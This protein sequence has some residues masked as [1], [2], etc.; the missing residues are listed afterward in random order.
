MKASLETNKQKMKMKMKMNNTIFWIL[1]DTEGQSLAVSCQ[2][3]LLFTLSM[4]NNLAWTPDEST[5]KNN[6]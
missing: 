2:G 5:Y 1:P 6:F 4:F 3:I